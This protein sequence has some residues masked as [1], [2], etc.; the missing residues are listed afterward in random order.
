M[1]AATEL[2]NL[3]ITAE[4]ITSTGDRK[5]HNFAA[6]GFDYYKTRFIVDG[7]V[8]EGIVDIGVS[9]KGAEFYGMTNIENVTS[10]YYGKYSNLLLGYKSVTQS[11]ISDYTVPQSGT[12]SQDYSMPGSEKNTAEGG[13]K[14]SIADRKITADMPDDERAEI[15]KNT[16]IKLAE[17]DGKNED[18]NSENVMLLKSSYNSQAG[19]ILKLLGEKFGVFKTYN[20]KN[21][22]LDFNYSKGSLYESVHKQGDISTDFYDFAKMLYVFDEVVENAVPIEVHIDKYKGTARENT[23]LKYDYVLL[24]AF[25]DGKYII[26]VELHLKEMNENSG[27]ENKLYVSITLGKIKTED[28]V[29]VQASY[30]SNEVQTENTRLSSVISIPDLISKIN[31]E[32]GNFYKYLPASMLNEQQNSTRKTAVDDENYRLKVMRSED[33]TDIL[34]E[35]ANEKGYILSGENPN[36]VYNNTENSVKTLEVTYDDNGNLIPLSKR[37]DQDKGDIR[38]SI[39]DDRS[40]VKASEKFNNDIGAD[41]E[42]SAFFAPENGESLMHEPSDQELALNKSLEEEFAAG[43]QNRGTLSAAKQYVKNLAELFGVNLEWTDDPRIEEGF[44]NRRTRTIVLSTGPDTVESL[45]RVFGH[46]L[47]HYL[48]SCKLYGKFVKYLTGQSKSFAKFVETRLADYGVDTDG[49]QSRLDALLDAIVK[50]RKTS[51]V[52]SENA[53]RNFGRDSAL[54]ELAADFIGHKVFGE[55]DME[56]VREIVTHQPTVFERIMDWIRSLI[57]R[58]TGDK[59][60]ATARSDM[61]YILGYLN[62]VY[63]SR[64]TQSSEV[65]PGRYN[66]D[67]DTA[68][69]GNTAESLIEDDD[70]QYSLPIRPKFNLFK[71]YRKGNISRQT[72]ERELLSFADDLYKYVNNPEGYRVDVMPE[73]INWQNYGLSLM[74]WRLSKGYSQEYMAEALDISFTYLN[75]IE[76]GKVKLGLGIMSKIAEFTD[77]NVSDFN[78]TDFDAGMPALRELAIEY[79]KNNDIKELNSKLKEQFNIKIRRKNGEYK[80]PE[81]VEN[82]YNPDVTAENSNTFRQQYALS[83]QELSRE[84]GVSHD[85]LYNLEKSRNVTHLETVAKIAA[86]FKVPIDDFIGFMSDAEDANILK[87]KLLTRQFKNGKLTYKQFELGLLEL[88]DEIDSEKSSKSLLNE[89][90]SIHNENENILEDEMQNIDHSVNWQVIKSDEYKQSLYKLSDNP[91]VVNTIYTRI[92]WIL[93]HK[94]GQIG[95]DM[96]AVSLDN[97]REIAHI[98]DEK[99]E[100]SSVTRTRNFNDLLKQADDSGEKVLLIHNH[101]ASMPASYDDINAL[102]DNKNVSGITVGHNGNIRYYTRPKEEILKEEIGMYELKYSRY[103][104]MSLAGDKAREAVAEKRGFIYIKIFDGVSES[105]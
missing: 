54:Y 31:P 76:N 10:R 102:W 70:N 21:V 96:Y 80:V 85:T 62:R 63:H 5:N 56:A 78:R 13:N 82:S 86:F 28:K 4:Y 2:D 14:F 41:F 44:Y 58:I 11:D 18:L 32:F 39:P 88:L 6:D 99:N 103:Y 7:R 40:A 91:K 43:V 19:K 34:S 98:R 55:C 101:P 53:R 20:N 38:F 67:S 27:Q 46:E 84:I 104:G 87:L 81:K 64:R 92:K 68:Y 49:T 51:K 16:V 61:E 9:E 74:V 23:K 36:E 93:T 47:A 24:S 71:E 22:S 73:D 79:Q 90:N 15:L 35:K 50:K 59:R 105:F 3:L 94:D 95:E 48:E 12:K 30:T 45:I 65:S 8:F 60:F 17:Y 26:P 83:R 25:R 97:G 37:Y 29:K 75:Q 57:R 42:E 77:C 33:V 69:A 89:E 1:K 52:M 66:R 72:A 100:K